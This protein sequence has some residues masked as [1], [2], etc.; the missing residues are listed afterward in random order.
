MKIKTVFWGLAMAGV[1][2]SCSGAKLSVANE[3]YA[4][5]EYY[6]AA[7][8]YRKVYGKTNPR[9][10][11]KLRGEIAFKMGECYRRINMA[12]RS[13]A[14]YQN[15]IRYD[16][17]D[18]MALFYLARSQQFEGK[19]KEAI[20]NYQAF[21]ETNPLSTLAKNGI[22]GCNLATQWKENPTRYVVKKATILNSRRSD[23]SPMY[24]GTDYD[25][26]YFTTST[27]KALGKN[28][29]GITGTKNSDIYFSKK[30]ERGAWQKP[31]P[32][33][34]EVNTED[35]EGVISFSPDGTTMYLS[36]ARR[37]P[38]ADT[39]V[40]I[41]TSTRTGAQWSAAKKYE[42]TADTLSAFGHP[43]VSPDGQYLYFVSDMPGGYGG[44]DLWRISLTEKEGTL[45]NL[46][47][48]INTPGDEMFPYIRS[49]GDLYF[50]SDGHPGMGGLDIFRARMNDSGMWQIENMKYPVNS[51]ADDFGITFGEEETG[52]FSSNRGDGRGYD[53]IYTFELPSIRVWISGTVLD[54]D[55]EPVPDAII[56]IVGNDGSNQ[57]EFARKD[58]S[59]RFKLDRGVHYVMLATCRGYLNS[60]QEFISDS[61]EKDAEYGVNFVLASISKP[62]LIENIFYDFDRATLR[63]ESEASLN[64]LVKML[65]DN[66]NVSIELGAHTDMKGSEQYNQRLS[67]RRAQSVVDY[68]IKSGIDPRRLQPKGYGESKPKVI[69]KKLATQYPQFKEG[70]VLT[71]EYINSLAPEDQEIA[72]QINRR[73]EF[74]VLSITWN[75]Y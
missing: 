8:T 18:S 21:L 68:L 74:Q 67:D 15:A 45:E 48:Q 56:R 50:A 4:R 63:P 49:N 37:E 51:S 60:K 41:Y 43:A 13:T 7:Q 52:F 2:A 53:N 47:V 73:T 17:P 54:K 57:K 5:G 9:K 24:L 66:P 42:I 25:Q 38:N 35:D 28:K 62:I 64:E 59:F 11:R 1:L 70:D 71:E 75:L 32:V 44:K 3:Q 36:K 58:G 39:S 19:Y 26:I 27:E 20:K 65:N 46:G 40:E 16:Y 61:E 22:R 31:E 55:D 10:E 69:T 34:G 72:N 12:P 14:A 30:D 33:E 6:D 29:S 23:F